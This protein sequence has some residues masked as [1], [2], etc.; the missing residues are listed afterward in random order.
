[1]LTVLCNNNNNNIYLTAI[2]LSPGG[3]VYDNISTTRFY[4]EEHQGD[5]LITLRVE[6]QKVLH[7]QFYHN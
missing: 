7:F 6:E 5:R 4:L 1:L 3:S 2:G